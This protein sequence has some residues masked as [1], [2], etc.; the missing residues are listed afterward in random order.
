M[1]LIL[2]Q[3]LTF[4]RC[5]APMADCFPRSQEN[6]VKTGERPRIGGLCSAEGF[7]QKGENLAPGIFAGFGAIAF[8]IGEGLETVA[9]PVIA[10]ENMRHAGGGERG[11]IV[12]DVFG[13]GAVIFVAE[14]AGNRALDIAR[15]FDSR[16]RARSHL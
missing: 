10:V 11:I 13:R 1:E 15:E 2:F 14:K 12:I 4:D 9:G 3:V 7:G 5:L 6:P 8:F 16:W